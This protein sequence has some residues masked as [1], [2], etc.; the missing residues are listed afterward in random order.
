MT[1]RRLVSID[2]ETHLIQE[3]LLT[4]PIVCGSVAELGLPGRLLTKSG[5]LAESRRLLEDHDVLLV[6]ANI[7]FDFGCLAVADPTLLRL[8]FEAYRRGRVHDILVAQA[9]DAIAKG[10]LFKEPNG[11]PLMSSRG[12]QTDRYS[13][14]ICVRLCLGRRDAKEHSFWRLR[15]ALLESLP[16]EEWPED[17]RRYPVDDAENT[18]L[19]A[20]RQLGVGGGPPFE[21]LGDLAA[22]C[23]TDW[24]LHLGAI[25]GLRTD[26]ARVDVLE[27]RAREL[28]EEYLARFTGHGFFRS[29]RPEY[30][31]GG[32][33]EGKV[34]PEAGKRDTCAVARAVA[35]AYGASGTC[36]ACAGAG[37]VRPLKKEPCRGEKIGNRF[38]GCQ[39]ADVLG[40]EV[41]C[42]SREVSKPGNEVICRECSGSGLQLWEETDGVRRTRVPMTDGGVTGI[43]SVSASRDTLAESGD[44]DLSVFGEA[45][46]E[47]V[48]KTYAPF[49][50]R[51]H[52]RP[53]T[54]EPN[55]LV[56]SG[57]ASYRGVI[58]LFPRGGMG[59]ATDDHWVPTP[60]ECIAARP[61]RV[62]GSSDY[63]AGELCALAQ[64]CLWTVGYSRMAEIINRTGDPGA[65]H[66][67]F[68]A[69]MV[70]CT[71]EELEARI[72][73]KDKAA[74]LA[75]QGSKAPN[76]GF[77]G[78]MGSPKF[79]LTNR[80]ESVG[81]T[82]GP[83][84]RKYAG[85][86]FCIT[87]GGTRSCGTTMRREW[88]HKSRAYE[89]APT[90]SECLD[91]VE[92]QLKPM[93]FEMFPEVREYHQWIKRWS[94]ANGDVFP[95]FGPWWAKKQPPHRMRDVSD[96]AST[97]CSA[98][99]NGFQAYIADVTKDALR[100]VTRESYLDEESCLYQARTRI[101]V[102]QHDELFSELDIE[103]AHLAGPRIGTIMHEAYADWIPDV[104]IKGVETALMYH[105]SKEADSVY[106]SDGKLL[107]WEPKTKSALVKS[108]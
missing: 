7:P 104:R 44:E 77:G 30:L 19:V 15:Y 58:M 50:R 99:N 48:L 97:F 64:V 11:M 82:E 4:P 49:L 55:V 5:V 108:V 98:A 17:A 81:T 92:N 101:P 16:H 71:F 38:Q 24:A 105:W 74:K 51:G 37:R 75:R 91:V 67:A 9:L 41:C 107:V 68:G 42:G 59:L 90:C 29:P 93:W 23:E 52:G 28:H 60:R 33:K 54:L 70:G 69:K 56:E 89:I 45:A 102:F 76:F 43:K 35:L 63:P 57:R 2:L 61:G 6:G 73:A 72:V 46:F 95:C 36:G 8:I 26:E 106:D 14:D 10:H 94:S 3:G 100:R 22:Q 20:A 96:A 80:K 53:I 47:K 66:T 79:V 31:A 13:L 32:K 62:F 65:L 88:G 86:R 34:D 25:W 85:T 103:L 78:G 87:V 84:G 40:C 39:A 12:T 1:A 27:A 21:N 83:D 18:V